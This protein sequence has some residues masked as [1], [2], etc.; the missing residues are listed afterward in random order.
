[1]RPGAGRRGRC[2]SQ[3]HALAVARARHRHAVPV[4]QQPVRRDA[5]LFGGRAWGGVLVAD[6]IE[7]YSVRSDGRL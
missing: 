2:F 6:R 7:E 4:S 5:R 3:I 1:M